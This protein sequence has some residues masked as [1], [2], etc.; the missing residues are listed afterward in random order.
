[1]WEK[2]L[3]T[4]KFL[5]F[6]ITLPLY[7]DG[8]LFADRVG[9]RVPS[10]SQTTKT[11]IYFFYIHRI[12]FPWVY[13]SLFINQI[14][15]FFL[16]YFEKIFSFGGRQMGNKQAVAGG[17]VLRVQALKSEPSSLDWGFIAHWSM[18]SSNYFPFLS[19]R[20]LNLKCAQSNEIRKVC[21]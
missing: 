13:K 5:S 19:F 21:I 3:D 17:L 11:E 4:A 7:S 2:I 9:D 12:C 10:I 16:Y 1:M 14:M 20:S 8:N 6:T 15:Y 18:I